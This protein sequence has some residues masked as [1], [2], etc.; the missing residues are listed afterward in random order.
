MLEL[1]S[2]P[3]VFLTIALSSNIQSLPLGQQQDLEIN[4]D[5][6]ASFVETLSNHT[7]SI[8]CLAGNWTS[9]FPDLVPPLANETVLIVAS[10]TIYSPSSISPFVNVLLSFLRRSASRHEACDEQTT[11]DSMNY[12]LLATKRM[13]FGVGGGVEEFERILAEKG[14]RSKVVWETAEQ[15]GVGRVILQ[16]TADEP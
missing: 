11:S 10:E 13:Y 1:A 2:I 12:A 3:N 4:A 15:T 14:G 6:V 16:I 9:S 5:S 7:I 8:S